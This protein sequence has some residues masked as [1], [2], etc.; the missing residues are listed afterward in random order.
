MSATTFWRCSLCGHTF[1]PA[2]FHAHRG[3][4]PPNH[5]LRRCLD[6]MEMSALGYVRHADGSWAVT[7]TTERSASQAQ[8]L[9]TVRRELEHWDNT[10][11]SLAHERLAVPRSRTKQ[12]G[13]VQIVAAARRR[14]KERLRKRRQRAKNVPPRNAPLC[15]PQ[16]MGQ[17]PSQATDCKA[18]KMRPSREPRPPGMR[19]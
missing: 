15:P 8:R 1:S 16:G 7:R 11:E 5:P 13:I 14:L 3:A 6:A 19:S 12:P 2:A 9:P 10:G 17:T 4:F 18:Q